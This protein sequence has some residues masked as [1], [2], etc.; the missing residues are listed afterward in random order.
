MLN[1]HGKLADFMP[2][3]NEYYFYN[4]RN[5]ARPCFVLSGFKYKKAGF[6][7]QVY[8]SGAQEQFEV[9]VFMSTSKKKNEIVSESLTALGMN[10]TASNN[11]KIYIHSEET[12]TQKLKDITAGLGRLN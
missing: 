10:F 1:V 12:L 7:L 5:E 3:T 2:F 6:Q 4:P 11:M 9:I 8:Y